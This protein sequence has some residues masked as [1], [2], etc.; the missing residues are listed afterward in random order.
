V[1]ARVAVALVAVVAI[2]WLA[3]ME[4]DHRLVTDGLHLAGH[5]SDSPRNFARADQNLRDAG[6]LNPD[7]RPELV[8]SLLYQGGGRLPR[9][10]ALARDVT[11]KEPSNLRAW[12]QVLALSP[13]YAP[14]EVK[15][16][17][18]ALRRLDPLEAP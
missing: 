14:A 4:R 12:I 15:P 13:R 2:A 11:R 3:V 18:V 6:F 7:T 1:I 10:L 16:A 17:L 8:R 9:S 5:L